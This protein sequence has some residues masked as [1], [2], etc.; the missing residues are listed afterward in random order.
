MHSQIEL[1]RITK[2]R[3][4]TLAGART[5]LSRVTLSNPAKR[6]VTLYEAALKSFN[7]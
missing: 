1:R 5:S 7:S 6:A 3:R 2:S 4:V